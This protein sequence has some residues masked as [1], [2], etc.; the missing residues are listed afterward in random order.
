MGLWSDSKSGFSE[1]KSTDPDPWESQKCLLGM[2]FAEK[3]T[4][5]CLYS[6]AAE[7]RDAERRYGGAAMRLRD[8][9]RRYEG[10]AMRLLDAER[11]MG[12]APPAPGER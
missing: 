6:L 3:I 7:L 9:E 2:H 5:A 8:A 10:A 1:T 11:R 4:W 12:V